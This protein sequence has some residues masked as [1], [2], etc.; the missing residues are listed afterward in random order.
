MKTFSPRLFQFL[1]WNTQGDLGPWTFYT[2]R[3]GNLVFFPKAP[4][5]SPPTPDQVHQRN[6]FR[7]A[8]K[9]WQALI[10]AF[11]ERWNTAAVAAHLR[12]H[13]YDLWTY[14]HLTLDAPAIRTI[15]NQTRIQLLDL[16]IL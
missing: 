14:Y 10:P 9:A 11:R 1:G 8:A 4:P 6:R 5:L 12:I 16:E 15:E 13:G 2:S 3:R 7:L